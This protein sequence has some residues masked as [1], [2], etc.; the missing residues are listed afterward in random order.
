[1]EAENIAPIDRIR[2]LLEEGDW[3]EVVLLLSSLHP[4]DQ[5]VLLDAV[6]DVVLG[7]IEDF[8]QFARERRLSAARLLW[9]AV[10]F[11][12]RL[13]AQRIPAFSQDRD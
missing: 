9:I 5:A 2:Q 3:E 7:A 12:H 1:M 10:G 11:A 13:F 8:G 4:A 6:A